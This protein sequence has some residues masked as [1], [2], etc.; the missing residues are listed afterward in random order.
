M[1][2]FAILCSSSKAAGRPPDETHD[3]QGH[4][5]A[6]GKRPEN[7]IPAFEYC[8][9]NQMTTIELDTNV[10]KDKQLIVNHDT[11][12]NGKICRYED[13]GPA[14]FAPIKDLTVDQLKQLDCGTRVGKKD[15]GKA[16]E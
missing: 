16:R 9:E 10:T 11:T 5:G 1:N 15:I 3:L 4:R 13:G 7:T 6:R 12:V 14:E 2:D 8:I